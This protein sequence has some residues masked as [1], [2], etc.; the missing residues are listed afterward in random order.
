VNP[1]D[2]I[3][4]RQAYVAMYQY[5][6]RIYDLTG[7]DELGG[8]LGSMSLLPD[9]QPADPAAWSDWLRAV[10]D[11]TEGAWDDEPEEN[12]GDRGQQRVQLVV[13]IALGSGF[14]FPPPPL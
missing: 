7:S 6:K 10:G 11:A 13:T 3:S 12:Q 9:G 5:L 4:V 14:D 1:S 2:Q 8:L